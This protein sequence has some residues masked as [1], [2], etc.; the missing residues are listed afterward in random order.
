MKKQIAIGMLAV[1]LGIGG[2]GGSVAWLFRTSEIVNTFQPGTITGDI[3]ETFDGNVK[4]DVKVHNEGDV[5]VY[6]RVALVPTWKDGENATGL[7]AEGTYS[8][9]LGS[10]KWFKSADG[11]YYYSVP[12][13]AGAKTEVLITECKPLTSLG[14]AYKGKKFEL[15][16]IATMIQA[17]PPEAVKEAW[18]VSVDSDGNISKK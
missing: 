5:P 17:A 6:I 18:K 3:E 10:N 4:K 1:V 11:F 9:T 12:V 16:V 13:A 8:L 15:D 7:V 14:E 2:V